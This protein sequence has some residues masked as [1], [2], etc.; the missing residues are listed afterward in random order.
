MSIILA[1]SDLPEVLLPKQHKIFKSMFMLTCVSSCQ[2]RWVSCYLSRLGWIFRVLQ[3][4]EMIIRK[5]T[6][7]SIFIYKSH[8]SQRTVINFLPKVLYSSFFWFLYLWCVEMKYW[9]RFK[10]HPWDLLWALP[11]IKSLRMKDMGS[12]HFGTRLKR[13]SKLIPRAMLSR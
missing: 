6:C 4:L 1:P 3:I 9:W 11:V 8:L 13:K 10:T 12:W 2:S 5:S 7:H